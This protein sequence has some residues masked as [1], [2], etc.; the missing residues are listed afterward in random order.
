MLS[1][2][3]SCHRL[4]KLGFHRQIFEKCSNVKFHENPPG[5]SQVVPRGRTDGRTDGQTS[6][7]NSEATQIVSR[8]RE[9]FNLHHFLFIPA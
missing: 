5:G 1:N 9:H 8:E 7:A 6:S 2:H 3:Y 4:M